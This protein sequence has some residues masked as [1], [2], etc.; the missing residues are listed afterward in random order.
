[1]TDFTKFEDYLYSKMAV[2][3]VKDTIRKMRFFDRKV[4]LSSRD[5][6]L[7]FLRNERRNGALAKT[8]NEHIK[9][10]NRW[11]DFLGQDKII[12]LKEKRSF[13][14]KYYD[15]DQIKTIL[16]K[17]NGSTVEDK[18]NHAMVLLALNTGLRRAEIA[19]LKVEDIHEY[20]ISVYHGKGEKDR[21]VFLDQNTR[22]VLLEYIRIRNNQNSPFVFTTK[23]S[24][25]TPE[26]MG[27][28]A[29]T[30][31][32]KSNIP[33]SWHK[34]RHTYAHNLVKEDVDLETIRQMLGH[35]NLGTTQIYAALDSGEAIERIMRKKPH[36]VRDGGYKSHTSCPQSNGPKGI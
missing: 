23:T 13:I 12:Y 33:F 16:E 11:L 8:I 29:M 22:N 14:V 21:T 1:M 35:E 26:Y 28:I 7:E 32:K 31:T 4:D 18:R 20:T 9:Y 2:S 24:S 25:V 5:A 19:A 15:A 3:T 6:I 27:K 36:F 17:S 10:L 30:I 34:C